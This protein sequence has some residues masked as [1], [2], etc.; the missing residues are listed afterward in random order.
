MLSLKEI[1]KKRKHC[2]HLRE[3]F[4]DRTNTNKVKY[5]SSDITVTLKN[6]D[7]LDKW[8]IKKAK[9]LTV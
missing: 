4:L 3:S 8:Y 9:E 7:D 5:F 2:K 1:K 6:F